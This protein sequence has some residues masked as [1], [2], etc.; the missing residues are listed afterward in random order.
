MGGEGVEKVRGFL[1]S[2]WGADVRA[3]AGKERSLP[4]M[5]AVVGCRL[6]ALAQKAANFTIPWHRLNC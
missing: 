5:E 6:A 1:L 2:G 4:K 3:R